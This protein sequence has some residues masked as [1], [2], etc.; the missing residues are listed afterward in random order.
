MI[1]VMNQANFVAI[2]LSGVVYKLFDQWVTAAEWPRSYIFAMMAMLVVPLLIAYRPAT[3]Q[4][5]PPSGEN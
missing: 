5:P 3:E 1:A 4:Q 2:L